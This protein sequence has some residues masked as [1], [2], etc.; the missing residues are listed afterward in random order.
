[1][2]CKQSKNSSK[3]IRRMT[4]KKTNSKS[5]REYSLLEFGI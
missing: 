1:L 3:G 4:G 5:Q 2:Q